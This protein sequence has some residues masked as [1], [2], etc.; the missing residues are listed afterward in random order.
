MAALNLLLQILE[1]SSAPLGRPAS[2]AMDGHALALVTCTDESRVWLCWI[3]ALV[4]SLKYAHLATLHLIFKLPVCRAC[5]HHEVLKHTDG[6][7]A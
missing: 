1:T 2:A 6:T 4:T 7:E 5:R 3:E